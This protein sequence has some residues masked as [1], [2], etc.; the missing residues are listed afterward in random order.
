MILSVGCTDFVTV[1]INTGNLP[2]ISEPLHRHA[3]VLLDVID[4]AID[5][6][7][8]ADIVEACISEWAANLVVVPKKDDQGRQATPRITID[9]RKL[10]AVTYK[11]KYP[12]LNTKD[13]L[14]S[15]S[16]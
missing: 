2:P 15:L 12:F 7:I 16:Q 10:N 11:D 6:M 8:E 4:E 1:T 14:H 13:C 3:R 9:F 5:K